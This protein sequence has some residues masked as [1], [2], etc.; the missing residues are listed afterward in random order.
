MIPESDRIG[1][2]GAAVQYA[3]ESSRSHVGDLASG[4]V[5]HSLPGLT[6]FPVRLGSELFLHSV[7]LLEAKGVAPPYHLY[8][9]TCGGGYLATVLGLL[10]PDLIGRITLSDVSPEAIALARRNMRLLSMEGLEERRDELARLSVNTGRPSYGAATESAGRLLA[11]RRGDQVS[12]GQIHLFVADITN[13]STVTASLAGDEVDIALADM[14]YGHRVQW[15][16]A[17]GISHAAELQALSTLGQVG[18]RTVALATR[19]GLKLN[20]PAFERR[21]KMSCGH[22]MLWVFERTQDPGGHSSP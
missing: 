7:A 3:F 8:D 9:P 14:P 10:H 20:Y 16:T 19:K 17:E 1:R 21:A 11:R 18:A 15:S 13:A 6:A 22:R 4:C 2:Q 12:L 5:I